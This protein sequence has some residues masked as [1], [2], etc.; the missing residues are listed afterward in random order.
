MNRHENAL[1][2]LTEAG[3]AH[4]LKFHDRLNPAQQQSLLEQVAGLDWP[5]LAELVESHVRQNPRVHLPKSLEPAPYY[6]A[7][8]TAAMENK[9][10]QARRLGEKLIREGKV[11]AF[12]V[13][14]GQGT[15]LG[16]DAPKGT[17]P[18]TPITGKPLFQLFAESLL[19]TQKKYGAVVPWYVMTS[20]ANDAPTRDFF[21][22][23]HYFG[24][25]AGQV[26]FFPQGTVPSF[27]LDGRAILESPGRIAVNPDG[28]GGS[29]RALYQSGAIADM[30]K[31]GVEQIS[32][33]QVDNP[34]VRCMDP[35]FIGLH[36]A[37]G[38]Q[39]SSKMVAKAHAGEK[40]G[41]FALADGRINVIEYS[42]LP[43]ELANATN[44]DG[45]LR[46][47][48]GSI[49]IHVI[50]LSFVE[51]LNAGRFGL[52]YHRAVKKVPGVDLETGSPVEPAKPNGVK[53]ETF[54]FDALQLCEKSIVL[55]TP[56]EE[57]FAP[58]K[59]AEGADSP[60]TSRKMQSD[61]AA[62][63]LR[64]VGVKVADNAVIELSPL[65]ALEPGDL[66]EADRPKMIVSGNHLL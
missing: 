2:I 62:R 57:E 46:F 35:L 25:D 51:K 56:R 55:E 36:A 9:Y 43:A 42:D 38:A 29:L 13:A 17:F 34:M 3:Q 5:R 61:R 65:T 16:W 58:I 37:E 32:Y 63:W 64:A 49:A 14:G 66:R 26:F 31:R 27:S 8:P 50:A 41:V 54:V 4:V 47:N 11:A 21:A 7:I 24:L 18:A 33:F 28:H 52:P 19:K 10:A 15:R 6:P 30:K 22:A 48:A 39:M 12:I 45:S 44:P 60:A 20:P 1:K 59:N 40:V 23:H 53:L